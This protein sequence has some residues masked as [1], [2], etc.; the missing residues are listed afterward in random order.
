[1]RKE[2]YAYQA[3]V[4]QGRCWGSVTNKLDD[5]GALET[6]QGCDLPLPHLFAEPSRV[7]RH[8][9]KGS[10]VYALDNKTDS[11]LVVHTSENLAKDTLPKKTLTTPVL[12]AF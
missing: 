7:L 10:H 6:G 3:E 5:A 9:G 11:K 1:M 8:G 2:R 4:I 12:R